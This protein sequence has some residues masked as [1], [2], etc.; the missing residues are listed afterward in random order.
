MTIQKRKV[1]IVD[2]SPSIRRL[3]ID[4][5]SPI[6]DIEIVGEAGTVIQAIEMFQKTNP[7]VVILDLQ[8][9][10]GNGFDVLDHIKSRRPS[11]MVIVLTNHPLPQHRKRCAEIGAEYFFDKSME[12]YKIAEVINKPTSS[13]ES[14]HL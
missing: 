9:P 4:L 13:R 1:L 10:E 8:Y 5:L 6:A 2:D 3:V 12:F 7:D 11:T 14:G